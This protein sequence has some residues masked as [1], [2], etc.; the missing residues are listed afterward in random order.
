[1]KTEKVQ[2]QTVVVEHTE[3]EIYAL[4]DAA[5]HGARFHITGG[6]TACDIKMFKALALRKRRICREKLKKDKAAWIDA[7]D[8]EKDAVKVLAAEAAAQNAAKLKKFLLT[9]KNLQTLLL[10]FGLEKKEIRSMKV[11]EMRDCYNKL[12]DDNTPKKEYK[13]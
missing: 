9:M 1:M 6:V 4:A 11:G 12:K 13:K 3:E 5:S 10:Y 8:N 7:E 2:P